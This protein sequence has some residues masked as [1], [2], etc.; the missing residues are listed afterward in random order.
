MAGYELQ[1]ITDHLAVGPAP[2]SREDMEVI[3]NAGINSIVNLGEEIASLSAI[4]RKQGFEVFFLPVA[5]DSV[6]GYAE[7]EDALDWLDEALYLGRKV[8]VHCRYGMGRTGTFVTT[9]LIRRGF[10]LKLAEKALKNFRTT[11][12]SY[13]QWCMLR[14]YDKSMPALKVRKADLRSRRTL[15]LGP[16]FCDYEHIACEIGDREDACGSSHALCCRNPFPLYLIEAAW[17]HHAVGV[18]LEQTSRRALL[19]RINNSGAYICA[20]SVEGKCILFSQRPIRCKMAGNSETVVMDAGTEKRLQQLSKQLFIAL[21]GTL[22]PDELLEYDIRRVLS[23]A[24]IQDYFAAAN[25]GKSPMFKKN[26]SCS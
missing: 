3:R 22:P 7:L 8:L 6:P 9:Y 18:Q 23:G 2:L 13:S 17:L 19:E 14:N 20:L 21:T 4:E 25:A 11:P 10:G 24:F 1:W 16:F 15:D 26:G 12:T 5:D